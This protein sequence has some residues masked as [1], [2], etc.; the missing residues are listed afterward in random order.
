MAATW[1]GPSR[2]GRFV[3]KKPYPLGV[4]TPTRRRCSGH[5]VP[6]MHIGIN[7]PTVEDQD[8]LLKE[9]IEISPGEELLADMAARE[10]VHFG[11][12]VVFEA[13]AKTH[14]VIVAG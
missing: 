10:M 6:P 1:R 2:G 5:L 8:V 3:R 9:G 4:W 12:P 13:D 7:G 14:P 11:L